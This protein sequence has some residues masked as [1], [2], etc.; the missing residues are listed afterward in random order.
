LEKEQ[1]LY[2]P[3]VTVEFNKTAYNNE[4]LFSQWIDKKFTS[5]VADMSDVLLVMDVAS[6]HKTDHIKQRLKKLKITLALIPPGLTS[7][8][9][10]LDTAVNAP[11]KLWLQEFT[12]AYITE[13]E[14]QK[15]GMK[16]SVSDRRIMTTWTVAQAVRR[17][18]ERDDLVQRAFIQTRISIRPDGTQDYL[19]KIK[20]ITKTQI[21]W[22]GWERVEDTTVGDISE[23]FGELPVTDLEEV[24]EFVT[25][26]SS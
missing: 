21:S 12:N 6:F 15:P 11:I 26:D 8:L 2:S 10:P 5:A 17:L 23:S 3:D 25:T 9:Q 14:R 19:I 24:D 13:K 16:W 22:T 7:F 18:E 20:D 1:H 4:E